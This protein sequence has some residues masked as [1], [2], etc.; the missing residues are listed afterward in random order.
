MLLNTNPKKSLFVLLFIC[1]IILS[2]PMFLRIKFVDSGL[3]GQDSY[4]NYRLGEI[5][6]NDGLSHFDSLSFSGKVLRYE[7]GFPV[8]IS[9][10]P[11][12][13]IWVLPIIFGLLSLWIFYLILKKYDSDIALIASLFL[14]FSPPFI[15]LFS[16]ATKFCGAI[17]FF[18]LGYYFFI[19]KTSENKFIIYSFISFLIVGLFSVELEITLALIGLYLCYRRKI[20]LKY[21]FSWV[22]LMF[23]IL[24]LQFGKMLFDFGVFF[25]SYFSKDFIS[26]SSNLF[27]DIGGGYGFSIFLFI[28]M[29]IGVFYLWQAKYRYLLGYFF[30]IILIILCS[31]FNFLIFVLN[32]AL[33]ILSAYGLIHLIDSE[34][35]SS[36]FRTLALI[37]ILCGVLFS[38]LSFLHNVIYIEPSKEVVEGINFLKSVKGNDVVFSDISKGIYFNYAGK[39]NVLDINNIGI[40]SYDERFNDMNNVL[41]SKKIKDVQD[42][43]RKYKVGYVWMDKQIIANIYSNDEQE[44]LFL[45][46]YAPND[47]YKQFDNGNVKIWM[48]FSRF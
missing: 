5:V 20:D 18:L 23:I 9:F 21:Y 36:V 12:V 25:E 3:I 32:F 7:Y 22:V 39:R 16:V 35:K 11:K 15:Y 8:L 43:F 28:L 6:H 30:L 17:F 14:I 24:F 19:N 1:L 27:F 31:Y 45:L 26:L 44:F 34:W 48:V 46:K 42:I 47:F 2:I 41:H 4:Y 29:V 37:I 40:D 33:V 38:C 13:M 10:L